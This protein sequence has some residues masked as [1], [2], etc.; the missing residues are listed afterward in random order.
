MLKLRKH[1]NAISSS[2]GEA[3]DKTALSLLNISF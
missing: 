3:L 2:R 1:Q